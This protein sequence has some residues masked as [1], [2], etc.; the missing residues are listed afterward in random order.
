MPVTSDWHMPRQ[1]SS[2]FDDD[3][4]SYGSDSTYP[5][6]RSRTATSRRRATTTTRRRKEPPP[7]DKFERNAVFRA[8]KKARLDPSD[9]ELHERHRRDFTLR[10]VGGREFTVGAL[11]RPIP[12]VGIEMTVGEGRQRIRIGFGPKR[13][14]SVWLRR[15]RR[16]IETPD[17]WA[18]FES[19]RE[20]LDTT[21]PAHENDNTGFTTDEQIEIQEQLDAI[22]SYALTSGRFTDD[23]LDLLNAKLDR[24]IE[25]SRH[26]RRFD[27]RDQVWGALLGAIASNALPQEATLEVLRMVAGAVGHLFGQPGLLPPA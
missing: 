16:D 15:V 12:L 19:D 9:F 20:L 14:L 22:R 7:F 23:E 13:A 6:K 18:R 3:D 2:F 11:D 21:A 5:L 8:I 24:L 27:W 10:H 26:S 25:S 4:P 17:L 1:N